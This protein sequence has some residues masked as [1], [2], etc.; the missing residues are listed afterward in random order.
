MNVFNRLSAWVI[1][2]GTAAS[3]T[4]KSERLSMTTLSKEAEE[5][6]WLTLLDDMDRFSQTFSSG[7]FQSR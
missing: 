6:S 4:N 2:S 7:Q 5:V 1:G 3:R